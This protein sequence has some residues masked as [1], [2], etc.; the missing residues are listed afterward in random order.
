MD[1]HP[2]TDVSLALSPSDGYR[3]RLEAEG[4]TTWVRALVRPALVALLV[5]GSVAVAAAGHVAPVLVFSTTMSWSWVV[6]VQLAFAVAMTCVRPAALSSARAVELW[7]AGHVPW[8][9]WLLLSVAL[10]RLV[11]DLPVEAL[12]VSMLVPMAWT[13]R[14]AAAFAQVVLERSPV[15]AWARAALH[16]AALVA[17]ILSYVAWAAGGWFRL[18][19]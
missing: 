10:L 19:G 5:G 12:I 13:A 9:V 1:R 14:I 18:A 7:F 15:E 8:T 3:R 6:L 17:V 16:Q 4:E 2:G 11:P